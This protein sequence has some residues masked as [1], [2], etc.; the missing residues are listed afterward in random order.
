MKLGEKQKLFMTL[1]P[2]LLDYAH[3]QGYQVTMG[4]GYRDPRVF[5]KMGEKSGYGRMNS[6][7]KQRLAVDLNLFRDG[8]Y[9]TQTIDH[10]PLGEYWEQL[11][12]LCRWGGRY[13]DGN[14]Y[15]LEHQGRQ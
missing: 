9:L 7:H 5:G 10:Q 11:H 1:L 4:D 13:N 6:N 8:D 12:E 14:H 15:S 2:R 3:Q